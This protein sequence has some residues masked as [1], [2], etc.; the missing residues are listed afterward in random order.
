[1]VDPI[2]REGAIGSLKLPNRLIRS[3]T[4][5]RMATPDGLVTEPMVE[6][7]RALGAGGIGLIVAGHAYVRADGR[8]RSNMS[9]IDRDETI[10]GW[11][12][13][14]QAVH[15]GGGRIAAQ[16]NHG[17]RQTPLLPQA[18]VGGGVGAPRA[19]SAVPLAGVT[20]LPLS[21]EEIWALIDAFAQAA[22]RA[23]EAGF[24]AVQIHAA[25]GYLISSFNSPYTN[26]RDDQWGGSWGNRARFLREVIKATRR[27]VGAE[28]P[29]LI[30][31]NA[32][33]G[34][35]GG[36]SPD[37]VTNI[38]LLCQGLGVDAIE[39]SGGM[40]DAPNYTTRTLKPGDRQA[41]FAEQARALHQAVRV[42]IIVVGG[43]RS[44]EMANR[45]IED[46]TADFVALCRP[47]IREPDLAR[48]W[49]AGDRRPA[50]CISCNLCRRYQE[51]PVRC[52]T[53]AGEAGG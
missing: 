34:V 21:E 19:P 8:A 36:I 30:K 42:P 38:A 24:D 20:P 49:A 27:Q 5:E 53:L 9:G 29:L 4:A 6:M 47:F 3:A 14:V 31:L 12:R 10:A 23:Q 25:H 45:L 39:V 17:G 50:A 33:D 2:F 52:E 35:K 1:M 44:Y 28:Y 16:I 18:G 40:F 32:S 51:R 26:R 22:R 48:R 7:Y 15:E 46:W 13:V 37:D 11:R 43:I 41:Y